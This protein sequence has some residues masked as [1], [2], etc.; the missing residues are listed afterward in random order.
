MDSILPVLRKNFLLDS[1]HKM[2][3]VTN[4]FVY[5]LLKEWATLPTPTVQKQQEKHEKR[6]AFERAVQA[7]LNRPSYE[8]KLK[9]NGVDVPRFTGK[10]CRKLIAASDLVWRT[11]DK[12]DDTCAVGRVGFTYPQTHA[13]Y[14]LEGFEGNRGI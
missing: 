14:Y 7:A 6:S 11:L 13:H 1:L 8:I 10:Q 4:V 5:R 12:S 3:R 2:M 9:N